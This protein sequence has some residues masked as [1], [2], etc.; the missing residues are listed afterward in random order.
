MFSRRERPSGSVKEKVLTTFACGPCISA[1][2]AAPLLIP[3]GSWYL[4]GRSLPRRI[5]TVAL[6]SNSRAESIT[7][8]DARISPMRPASE[9]LGTVTRTAPLGS[10][11]NG[12]KVALIRY[13]APPI[14]ASASTAS[15]RRPKRPRGAPAGRWGLERGGGGRRVRRG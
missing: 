9:P 7:P 10:S 6:A 4:P 5:V 8:A 2:I 11:W 1:S 15:T 12:W 13:S 14:S 3:S